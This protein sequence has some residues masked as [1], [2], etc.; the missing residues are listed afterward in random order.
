MIRKLSGEECRAAIATGDFPPA[1]TASAAVVALV[2]TQSWCP[3][4][5]WMNTYLKDLAAEPGIAIYWVEYD[6][7]S[8]YEEFLTFK[9]ETYH[10]R[11]IPYIR[12]YHNGKL[13]HESNYIDRSGFLRYLKR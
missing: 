2:L 8:F 11:Q 5:T 3:Q 1:I 12:Y 13:V 10:N 9:E 7:E 4:W 6:Q